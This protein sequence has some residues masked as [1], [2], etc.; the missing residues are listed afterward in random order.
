MSSLEPKPAPIFKKANPFPLKV[1]ELVTIDGG[2]V[3]WRIVWMSGAE[4]TLTNSL[5]HRLAVAKDRLSRYHGS[6]DVL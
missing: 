4:A 3:P 6:Q 2:T 5:T 1:G